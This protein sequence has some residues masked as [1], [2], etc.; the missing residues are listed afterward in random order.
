M[1]K[2]CIVNLNVYCLFNPK[3]SAPMG[4]AELDM[5]I[6]SKG[7][8]KKCQVSVI[9]GDWGQKKNEI[10]GNIKVFRSTKLGGK[11]L[12]SVLV[13]FLLFVS[14]LIK[15]NADIYISSGAGAEI[16]IISLF[17][18]LR[19]KKFIYRTAHEIDC[20]GEYIKF[21]GLKGLFYQ[22]GLEYAW[23][24]V[25]SVKQHQK[26]LN[27]NHRNISRKLRHINLGI[28]LN[29]KSNL[30]DRYDGYVLWVARCENWKNPEVFIDLSKS[31]PQHKF[32]MICPKQNH[33]KEY[34]YSIKQRAANLPNL[35]FVDFV[36]F[37]DIQP[38]FNRAKLFVN[39][40]NFEGFT[41]TLI[42]SGLAG[43]PIVYLNANPDEVITKYNIGYFAAGDREKLKRDI[44]NLLC[45]EDMW[46][47]KSSA[48]S[49][50]V[51]KNHAINK[52][53][54]DWIDLINR[55]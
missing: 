28:F 24:V 40:S 6:L 31:F 30:E 38:Y 44:L 13:G 35:T 52:L 5:Y 25:T 32:I 36:P 9:T 45:N 17:C 15:T 48:I 22:Y 12:L 21:N 55:T 46:K 20:N 51:K 50:Y 43:T 4:G 37:K 8:E 33:N 54:I 19:R 41:Y 27:E 34:F 39:T 3:S 7:L 29:N 1:K 23:R 26:L 47:Q 14:A 11:G 2:V 49:Q 53:T 16:G 18:L 42:Q 10:F